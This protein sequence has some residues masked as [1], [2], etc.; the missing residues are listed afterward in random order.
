MSRSFTLDNLFTT[1]EVNT[2]KT[3]EREQVIT[4]IQNKLKDDPMPTYFHDR[5]KYDTI[6]SVSDIHAD[7][8]TFLRH[9]HKFGIVDLKVANVEALLN[10]SK[11]D[12]YNSTF[13]TDTEWTAGKNTLLIICGDIIDGARSYRDDRRK[14]IITSVDD[15]EGTFEILLHMFLRNLKIKAQHNESD[16]MLICGNHDILFDP[17]WS[18]DYIHPTA[19]DYYKKNSIIRKDMLM[20]FYKNFTLFFGITKKDPTTNPTSINDFEILFLHGGIHYSYKNQ[21]VMFFEE[22]LNDQKSLFKQQIPYEEAIQDKLLYYS[23]KVPSASGPVP[24]WARADAEDI[25]SV[26][27]EHCNRYENLPTI[28]VG[29]CNNAGQQYNQP[30]DPDRICTKMLDKDDVTYKCVYP[31]CFDKDMIPKNIN[32]DTMMSSCFYGT[33]E[34]KEHSIK[35]FEMLKIK[36]SEKSE[37]PRF[38]KYKTVSFNENNELI[39]YDFQKYHISDYRHNLTRVRNYNNTEKKNVQYI[40]DKYFTKDKKTFDIWK[41]LR[42]SENQQE[43]ETLHNN[44]ISEFINKRNS[45]IHPN[46]DKLN[47]IKTLFEELLNDKNKLKYFQDKYNPQQQSS[48]GGSKKKFV[49]KNKTKQKKQKLKRKSKKRRNIRTHKKL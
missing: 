7:Y 1:D 39:E 33:P 20:P 13:I 31:K 3:A 32:I 44:V 29:H 15:K 37:E 38:D 43:I 26:N 24:T 2:V 27:H 12:I 9:L 41:M 10:L 47:K 46:E 11:D 16:V 40:I 28:I 49:N 35:K 36:T 19:I 42:T 14:E 21:V 30:S 17:K 4:M 25:T 6:Y 23:T 22:T 34:E 18:V 5:N 48:N 8:R 45:F